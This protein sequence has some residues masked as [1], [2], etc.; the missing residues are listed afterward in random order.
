MKRIKK[1][2]EFQ[3]PDWANF[4]AIDENGDFCVFETKPFLL[5]EVK[6]EG[7]Y[8]SKDDFMLLSKNVS[9]TNWEESLTPIE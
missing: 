7:I 8:E 5:D 4:S 1:E 6:G 9:T 3:V 2:L